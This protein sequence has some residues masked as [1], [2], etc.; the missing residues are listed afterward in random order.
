[1]PSIYVL[2]GSTYN[3]EEFESGTDKVAMN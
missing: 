2:N 1:M 3:I